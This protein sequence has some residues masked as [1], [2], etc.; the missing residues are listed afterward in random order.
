[1]ILKKTKDRHL[2]YYVKYILSLH[3]QIWPETILYLKKQ[4][5][6]SVKKESKYLE[7]FYTT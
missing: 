1:M 6:D 3:K 7:K 4:L 2:D 5:Y